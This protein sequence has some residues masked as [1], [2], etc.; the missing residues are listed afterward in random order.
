MFARRACR[1]LRSEWNENRAFAPAVRLFSV[2]GNVHS[3]SLV[4]RLARRGVTNAIALRITNV[5]MTAIENRS[6]YC[7]KLDTEL[8]DIAEQRAIH[9]PVPDLLREHSG[10]QRSYGSAD[11]VRRNHVERII[12]PRA[13]S[14]K[15]REVARNRGDGANRDPG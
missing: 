9:R 7:H 3:D 15:N 13:G 5:A 1:A 10:K 14:P 11:P 12:E 4:F 8:V 2:L 6:A